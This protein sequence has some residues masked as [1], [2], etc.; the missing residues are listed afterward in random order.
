M[1]GPVES[2]LNVDEVFIHLKECS[3]FYCIMYLRSASWER[4]AS[5]RDASDA[6]FIAYWQGSPVD[7]D[8]T[9]EEVLM[10]HK[11]F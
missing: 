8:Y 4:V 10:M 7:S 11:V 3:D 6:P 9:L 2:D 5:Q 1:L